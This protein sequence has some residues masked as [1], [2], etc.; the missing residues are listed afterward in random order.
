MPQTATE[1]NY[2]RKITLTEKAYDEV[3]VYIGKFPKRI[4]HDENYTYYTFDNGELQVIRTNRKERTIEISDKVEP[5]IIE[6]INHIART[7]IRG[8]DLIR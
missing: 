5:E 7:E 4:R 6:S 1:P 8:S 3:M 2:E